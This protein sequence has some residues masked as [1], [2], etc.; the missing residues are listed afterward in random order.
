LT[1]RHA[2]LMPMT[3]PPRALRAPT[4]MIPILVALTSVTAGCGTQGNGPRAGETAVR[5]GVWT[6]Q[7]VE[8]ELRRQ[9]VG[10]MEPLLTVAVQAPRDGRVDQ[11]TVRDGDTV[12]A[13]QVLVRMAGPDIMARR[14]TALERRDQLDDELARWERLVE[15]GAA[16]PGEV[17]EANLRSLQAR[18]QLAE[19]DALTESYLLRAPVPGNVYGLSVGPGAQVAAGQTVLRVEDA[20]SWGLR[21]A[22]PAWEAHLLEDSDS[23]GIRD[24]AGNVLQV[25]RLAFSSDL[26]PGF[27]RV[28]LYMDGEIASRGGAVVEHR[29]RSTAVIIPWTAVAGQGETHWVAVV[30]PGDP[31]RI[32]RR[33]VEL[34]PAH[35]QGVEVAQGLVA[36]DRIVRYEPRS[37]PEGQAVE[38]VETAP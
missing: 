27:V 38:P 23:L 28:D 22:V 26:H 14:E 13:G 11:V 10:R 4:F 15:A 30:A 6:V 32:E 1:L 12:A 21:L 24:D 20:G 35:A 31:A 7:E 33:N 5:V 19:L 29:S 18:E 9:W 16:G 2:N 37:H 3:E 36:G 17:A 25:E 34:G 8:V